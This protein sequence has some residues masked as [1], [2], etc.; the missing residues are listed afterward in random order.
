[1]GAGFVA[2]SMAWPGVARACAAATLVCLAAAGAYLLRARDHRP[3]L[4]AMRRCGLQ[5]AAHIPA[6]GLIVTRGGALYDDEG[7]P[8]AHNE[9]MLFAWLDRRGF[10]YG[11]EELSFPTLERIRARG[12]RFWIAH[13]E[14]TSRKFTAAAR[15]RYR[16]IDACPDGYA[17]FDLTT[18]PDAAAPPE[19]RP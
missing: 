7:M 17:L 13:P 15:D 9:S 12:G 6:D 2:L 10:T 5:F 18:P 8:V 3:D 1:M 16:E 19:T 14:E 11:N 4:E